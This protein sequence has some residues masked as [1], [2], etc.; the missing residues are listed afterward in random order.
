MS[1]M[2]YEETPI[3]NLMLIWKVTGNLCV[4]FSCVET[5][6][7]EKY[8]YITFPVWTNVKMSNRWTKQKLFNSSPFSHLLDRKILAMDFSEVSH[9]CFYTRKIL[10]GNHFPGTRIKT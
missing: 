8:S 1:G 7:L 10:K 9:R 5:L 2:N 3:S 6:T 4:S